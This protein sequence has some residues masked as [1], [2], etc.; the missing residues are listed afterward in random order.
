MLQTAPIIVVFIPHLRK[1]LGGDEHIKTHD[2]LHKDRA[3]CI[4]PKI[5][6]TIPMVSALAPKAISRGSQTAG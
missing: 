3:G 6:G 1:A 5:A 4:N 2:N